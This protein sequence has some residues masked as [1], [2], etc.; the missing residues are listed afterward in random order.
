MGVTARPA[1]A[2]VT[3]CTAVTTP[4]AGT[5][6][7]VNPADAG[8]ASA[9]GTTIASN[10]HSI[11]GGVAAR[12]ACPTAQ[13]A[14]SAGAAVTA[15]GA[16]AGSSYCRTATTSGPPDFV[17]GIRAS[18]PVA[19]DGQTTLGDSIPAVAACATIDAVDA[20]AAEGDTTNPGRRIATRTALAHTGA[21]TAAG[22]ATIATHGRPA[23]GRRSCSALTADTG[24]DG[25]N[26]ASTALT[27]DGVA[28]VRS[29][30]PPGAAA[31]TAGATRSAHTPGAAG[32]SPTT[33]S[34]RRTASTT[35][36]ADAGG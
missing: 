29:R 11:S 35:D 16:P 34:F 33:V 27:A 3:A 5:L 9:A 22:T 10:R 28:A 32:S 25:G 19:T 36:T 18:A 4:V 7:P 20:V 21:G 6:R 15:D 2:A 24:A 1:R 17:G 13:A 14:D 23:D 31:T 30:R 12:S 8:R 26:A